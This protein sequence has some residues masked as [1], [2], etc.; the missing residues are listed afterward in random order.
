MKVNPIATIRSIVLLSATAI[1]LIF[2][3]VGAVH[4]Q[5]AIPDSVTGLATNI[6]SVVSGGYWSNGNEEG[7][8]RAVVAA[9]G[10]EH[11]GMKLYLQWMGVEVDSNTIVPLVTVPVAEV[12][13][14]YSGERIF[15][16]EIDRNAELGT[17][18]LVIT[19]S[20]SMPQLQ[21]RFDLTAG[22]EPGVYRVDEAE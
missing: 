18:H 13:T 9:G 12:N 16:I 11:V 19:A 4:A 21:T 17:L 2:G 22:G 8:F 7:F 14:A 6:Q 10:V 5:D 15:D 3:C 1:F 20:Q